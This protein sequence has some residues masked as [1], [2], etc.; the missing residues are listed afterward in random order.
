MIIIYN[1]AGM[2]SERVVCSAH[3]LLELFGKVYQEDGCGKQ[4]QVTS[5]TIGCCITISAI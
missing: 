4:Y 5:T 2:T 3:K 1:L